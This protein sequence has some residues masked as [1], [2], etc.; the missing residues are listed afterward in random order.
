MIKALVFDFDGLIF[1]TET[2]EYKA[3]VELFEEYGAELPLEV[4]GKCIGTHAS[5]FD[6]FAYLEEQIGQTVNREEL[7]SRKSE[8]V[9][10]LLKEEKALPGVEDYLKAAREAG[11]KIGLASSSHYDWVSRH[12]NFLGIAEYFECIK[13][14]DDVENVK[15]DPALYLKAAECLGVSPEEA[16]AFEDSANGALAAKRAGMYCVVIPN[17]VTKDLVFDE[18]DHRMETMAELELHLLIEKVQK[19]GE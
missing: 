10:E 18:V 9:N 8:R 13:T 15:P 14:A 11:L 17:S 6:P 12:L 4:W 1:D 3:M 5:F 2:Q 7:R 19:Q 16:L